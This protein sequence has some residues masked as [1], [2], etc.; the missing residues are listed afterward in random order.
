VRQILRPSGLT[1]YDDTGFNS[2]GEFPCRFCVGIYRETMGGTRIKI[3]WVKN[4]PI[5]CLS[6]EIVDIL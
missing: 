6:C 1:K 3:G 2:A 5:G 4:N